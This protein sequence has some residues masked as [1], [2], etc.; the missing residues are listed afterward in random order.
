MLVC[1]RS[2]ES[3]RDAAVMA[4]LTTVPRRGRSGL[5][6]DRHCSAMN[7]APLLLLLRRLFLGLLLWLA[8]FCEGAAGTQ[9]AGGTSPVRPQG[10][11]TGL[12]EFSLRGGV[13]GGG[14]GARGGGWG[15]GGDPPP[16]SGDPELLEAPKNFL[17]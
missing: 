13:W 12:P 8:V 2:W 4:A 14:G 15:C 6:L 7:M 3:S 10:L 1:D 17:A 11:Q 16:P 9:C 5:L